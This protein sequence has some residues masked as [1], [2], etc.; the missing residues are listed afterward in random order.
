LILCR[1]YGIAKVTSAVN[2]NRTL[3]Y[4]WIKDGTQK[5]KHTGRKIISE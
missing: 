5:G 2:L 3:V 1:K 4:K